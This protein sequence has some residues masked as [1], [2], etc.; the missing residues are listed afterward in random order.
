VTVGTADSPVSPSST[1]GESAGEISSIG[2][3]DSSLSTGESTSAVTLGGAEET[4]V[5]ML[6]L[7]K[8]YGVDGEGKG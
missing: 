1:G 5:D 6:R 8:L 7:A 3:I 2:V 4:G